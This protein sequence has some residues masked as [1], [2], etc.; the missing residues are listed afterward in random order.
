M[1]VVDLHGDEEVDRFQGEDLDLAISAAMKG[2]GD[3][4]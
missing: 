3:H 1:F 4:E 2:H